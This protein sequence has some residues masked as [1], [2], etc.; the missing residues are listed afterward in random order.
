[1][2]LKEC[3]AIAYFQFLVNRKHD[4]RCELFNNC[5]FYGASYAPAAGGVLMKCYPGWRVRNS[6]FSH[7]NSFFGMHLKE[8]VAIA[9]FQFSVIANMTNG[10]NYLTIVFTTDGMHLKPA[11]NCDDS[12]MCI[13][14]FCMQMYNKSVLMY[15]TYGISALRN[16]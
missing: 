7:K 13:I 1:M 6:A 15:S 2:H 16:N 5:H 3:V 14:I 4:K 11:S 9:Y 8:C 10:V 12:W